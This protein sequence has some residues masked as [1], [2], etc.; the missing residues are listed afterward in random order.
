MTDRLRAMV[1]KALDVVDSDLE[2]ENPLPAAVQVLKACGLYGVTWP[3]GSTDPEE[4]KAAARRRAEELEI[5]AHERAEEL[6]IAARERH[7]ARQRR[8][9]LASLS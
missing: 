4:L 5:A 2:G 6:E 3:L 7:Q 8:A 9:F 1:P